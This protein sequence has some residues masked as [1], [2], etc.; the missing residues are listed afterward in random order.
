MRRRPSGGPCPRHKPLTNAY[1]YSLK[2]NSRQFTNAVNWYS[3]NLHHWLHLCILWNN[4]LLLVLLLLVVVVSLLLVL[5]HIYI[6]IY[7]YIRAGIFIPLVRVQWNNEFVS[8]APGGGVTWI[9]YPQTV[10]SR[11]LGLP[12]I[13]YIGGPQ[14]ASARVAARPGAEEAGQQRALAVC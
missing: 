5:I 14:G 1:K 11:N 7:I 2:T 10:E 3:D 9:L 8:V 12:C 6:Y 4:I 13:I